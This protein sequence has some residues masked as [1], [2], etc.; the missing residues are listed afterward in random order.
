MCCH[1]QAVAAA[2]SVP[3]SGGRTQSVSVLHAATNT[4]AAPTQVVADFQGGVYLRY[5]N[6][7]GDVR[8]RVSQL[9][10]GRGDAMLNA[11]FFD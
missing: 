8:I 4:S 6:L 11:V 3:V 7:S 2:C 9:C 10:A 1:N 5:G